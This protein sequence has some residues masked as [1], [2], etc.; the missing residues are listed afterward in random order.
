MDKSTE[1]HLSFSA[2]LQ[3][4]DNYLTYTQPCTQEFLRVDQ[5]EFLKLKKNKLKKKN[6]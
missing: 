6:K 5:K 2:I 4:V 3:M 1:K